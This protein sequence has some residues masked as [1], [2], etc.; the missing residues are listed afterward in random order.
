MRN[1][2]V[3]AVSVLSFVAVVANAQTAGAQGLARWSPVQPSRIP[4]L[5][6]QP[7]GRRAATKNGWVVVGVVTAGSAL[8]G[9][10][11]VQVLKALDAPGKYSTL[12][13]A[14]VWGAVGATAGVGYCLAARCEWG[15]PF[16]RRGAR[17]ALVQVGSVRVGW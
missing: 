1:A 2:R 3:A 15:S 8:V 13:T 4:P 11:Q 14:A 16:Q 7:N 10:F 9:A 5:L 6:M 17:A 12:Q